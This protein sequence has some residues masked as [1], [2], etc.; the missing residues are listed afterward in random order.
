MHCAERFYL[1]D[2]VVSGPCVSLPVPH[3]AT[4]GNTTSSTNAHI[5][6]SNTNPPT[7]KRRNTFR[8]WLTNPVR[9]LSQNR[10][11]TGAAAITAGKNINNPGTLV[12]TPA[13][14]TAVAANNMP[15]PPIASRKPSAASVAASTTTVTNSTSASSSSIG[16]RTTFQPQLSSQSHASAPPNPC[17][18]PSQILS[19]DI[20]RA[21]APPLAQ[22][23]D[24]HDAD[25]ADHNHINRLD[26]PSISAPVSKNVSLDIAVNDVAN[27]IS[28]DLGTD[29]DNA[30]CAPP[31]MPPPMEQIQ[32]IPGLNAL[33]FIP[34]P[35]AEISPSQ[36]Q[37]LSP[38]SPTER[39]TILGV[40]HTTDPLSIQPYGI[41][42][43]N[44][45]ESLVV[46]CIVSLFHTLHDIPVRTFFPFVLQ[47]SFL[48]R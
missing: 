34:I 20:R 38:S 40:T 5:A 9:K 48:F 37:S 7:S 41:E 29:N 46:N 14:S 42:L 16:R 18:I 30:G 43:A 2:A 4:S 12:V 25:T 44:Q 13:T 33:N 10:I 28:G 15:L 35:S 6:E 47:S 17:E 39:P 21:S 11:E 23:E 1:A 36:E 3:N 45:I 19:E 22:Q 26:K 24:W 32:T 8:K 31:E 27:I